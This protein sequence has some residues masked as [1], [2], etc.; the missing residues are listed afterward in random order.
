MKTKIIGTIAFLTAA[1]GTVAAAVLELGQLPAA[2]QMTINEYL[3]NGEVELLLP[4]N[5]QGTLV[6]DV[7][8]KRPGT[9]RELHITPTGQVLENDPNFLVSG[10][11]LRMKRTSWADLPL[12]V[13]NAISGELGA[14][15]IDDLDERTFNGR[16]TYSVEFQRDGRNHEVQVTSEGTMFRV[17][18]TAPVGGIGSQTTIGT[19]AA[20]SQRV[21]LDDLPGPARATAEREAAGAVIEEIDQ[22]TQNG[23]TFYEVTFNREVVHTANGSRREMLV[24]S[25]GAVLRN[26]DV[27]VISPSTIVLSGARKVTFAELPARVQDTVR[28]QAGA[29]AIDRIEEGQWNERTT[30]LV[31]F[32]RNGERQE[33]VVGDDGSIVATPARAVISAGTLESRAPLRYARTVTFHELPASVQ[34]TLRR[35][36]GSARIGLIQRGTIAGQP[37]YQASFTKN[38]RPTEVRV[39]ENG[40]I[41]SHVVTE[42]A[43]TQP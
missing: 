6:Y 24:A 21:T 29:A 34:R 4:Q 17:D 26:R 37:A 3:A 30:Y 1:T 42:T 11:G 16:T 28:H 31:V 5:Y 15:P 20:V 18:N 41:I 43:P 32:Y 9:N 22:I 10:A 12:A 36:A 2:V 23:R 8:I 14:T 40:S 33:L 19:A 35:E 38:R 27:T 25:D 13:Q 39:A 7:Y